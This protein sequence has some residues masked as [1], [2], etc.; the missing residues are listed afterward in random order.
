MN[1]LY[2]AAAL[3]I[4]FGLPILGVWLL[5]LWLL[6]DYRAAVVPVLAGTTLLWIRERRA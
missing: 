3:V 5:G 6:G 2:R 1:N 4:M